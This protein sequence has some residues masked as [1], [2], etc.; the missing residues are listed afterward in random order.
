MKT[1]TVRL[2]DEKHARLKALAARKGISLNKLFE[3]FS[4]VALT[5]FDTETRFHVRAKRGNR[6][7]GLELLDKLDKAH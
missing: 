6:E 2:P 7:R 4:T 5:E 3:E 1:M